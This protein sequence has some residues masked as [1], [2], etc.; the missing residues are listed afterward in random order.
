MTERLTVKVEAFGPD[1]KAHDRVAKGLVGRGGALSEHLSGTD[2]ELLALEL[3]E[4]DRKTAA[5]RARE[6]YR[7]T[8]YDYENARAVHAVGAFGELREASV[9]VSARQ[10]RPSSAEFDA[11]VKIVRRD[12][13]LG[14]RLRD[15][16]LQP[17]RPM[18]PLVEIERP[19][20][21]VER[22]VAVGLLPAGRRRTGH[23][24][25]GVNMVRRK[26]VRYE[27]GAP[28]TALANAGLCGVPLAAG[29]PTTDQGVA[30]QAWVS[31]FQGAKLLWKFLAVRP[32]SSSGASGSG[33][34]LRYVD[35]RGKRVLY[36]AHVPILNVRYDQDLC[37]PYRDWQYQEGML[38]ATGKSVAAGFLLCPTPAKTILDTH[39]DTGNFLGTAIYVDGDEV[40]LICEMEAGWYRYVSEWRLAADGTIRPRFAFDATSSSCVCNRHHHHV[41]WRLDFDIRTPGDNTVLEFND[42]AIVGRAKWHTLPYEVM[43]LRDPAHMRRWRVQHKASGAAYDIHPGKNDSTAAG[44]PYAVGDVWLLHWRPGQIDDQPAPD[45]RIYI[46][47]FLNSE[48]IDGEDVVVW[49]GAHFTHDVKG[50][51][52][53][54]VVGPDLVPHHW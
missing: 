47:K 39:S 49:Y 21:Q 31:V 3:L 43:R 51:E 26:V 34:E 14:G 28:A 27:G 37:G 11:A 35:Y 33:V 54:H 38:Q 5:P 29:Q 45:T 8:Y 17:Y 32:S 16:T 1:Q 2:H 42:P 13:E 24:I 20:G 50:P 40:V 48:P 4:P 36:Q 46:G 23:E 41:Y 7:A 18:P 10:P 44:D 22:T 30:G 52:V 25:V 19:D 15:G 53:S 6:R 12:K 9:S